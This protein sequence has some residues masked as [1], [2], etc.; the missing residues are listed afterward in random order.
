[1][2]HPILLGF[3]RDF[4]EI[5]VAPQSHPRYCSTSKI[6]TISGKIAFWTHPQSGNFPDIFKK[7]VS[8]GEHGTQDPY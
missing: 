3:E 5:A 1:M 4:L 8:N 6:T 2:F 7:D